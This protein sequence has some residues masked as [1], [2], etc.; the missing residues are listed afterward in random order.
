M[1]AIYSSGPPWSGHLV[2]LKLATEFDL[3]WVADFRDQWVS[4]PFDDPPTPTALLRKD[5]IDEARVVQRADLI[6]CVVET[7]RRVLHE[8]YPE[9]SA[10]DI[11]TILNGFDPENLEASRRDG[12]GPPADRLRFVHTGHFYGKRRVE[13]FLAAYRKWREGDATIAAKSEL[14]LIGGSG[15]YLEELRARV[16]ASG[17]IES[18]HVEAEIPYQVSLRRQAEATVLLLVGFTGHGE[19]TQMSGKIFEYLSVRRPI[20]ALAPAISPLGEV[21]R[22]SGVRH[23]IVQP[24]DE[25]AIL[26]ALRQIGEAWSR[27]ELDGPQ[28]SESLAAFDRREQTKQLVQVLNLAIARRTASLSR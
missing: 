7:M 20:L 19:E 6:L 13:P 2:G 14:E 27:G 21:L 18:I 10:G 28:S 3:P 9:R 25:G 17:S 23:W 11:V 26:K 15:T 12:T 22:Q 16:L 5:L 1:D 4:D 8:R 24:N